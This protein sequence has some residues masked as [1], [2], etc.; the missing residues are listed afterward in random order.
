MAEDCGWSRWVQVTCHRDPR[1]CLLRQQRAGELCPLASPGLLACLL[2]TSLLSGVLCFLLPTCSPLLVA[3]GCLTL[4][5][6]PPGFPS[7]N[8]FH[9][10][11]T[12]HTTVVFF[13][14]GILS[15]REVYSALW[16]PAGTGRLACFR[17][18]ECFAK[19]YSD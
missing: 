17:Q 11:T 9:C 3:R 12:Q 19:F 6:P 7:H 1:P 8:V 4:Y 5:C 18:Q 13:L 15:Y 16:G 14:A 2:G 10:F